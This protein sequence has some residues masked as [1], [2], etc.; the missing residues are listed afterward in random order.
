MTTYHVDGSILVITVDPA[1]TFTER[2]AVYKALRA[3][4]L[5]PDR[6]LL[7]IDVRQVEE[8]YTETVLR[9]RVAVFFDALGRKLGPVCALVVPAAGNALGKYMFQI[10]ADEN[11]VRVGLFDD[12]AEAR[13]WLHSNQPV[14]RP[15]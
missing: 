3:D 12:E 7:L 13:Q 2:R 5:V 6:A 8:T 10:I 1:S 4:R 11:A 15:D 14:E 9:S